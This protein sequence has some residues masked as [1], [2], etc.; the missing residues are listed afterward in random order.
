MV[1]RRPPGERLPPP[2]SLSRSLFQALL[3]P[4]PVTRPSLSPFFWLL[5][6]PVPFSSPCPPSLCPSV[7]SS[8]SHYPSPQSP[9]RSIPRRLLCWSTSLPPPSPPPSSMRTGALGNLTATSC[10]ERTAWSWCGMTRDNGA[11]CPAT[12]TCPT[13]ARWGWVSVGQED[14]AG[15]GIR[16][17]SVGRRRMQRC[18]EEAELC[19]RPWW[20]G[21]TEQ[22]GPL[23]IPALFCVR[24]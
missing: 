13:R 10:P 18:K 2:L 15:L 21:T 11:M 7:F 1:R 3:A 23:G 19:P 24:L 8:G 17:L 22:M 20:G 6:F 5:P 4:T 12:T 16:E 14:G 9:P